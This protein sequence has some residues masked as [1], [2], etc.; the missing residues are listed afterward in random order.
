[1]MVLILNVYISRHRSKKNAKADVKCEHALVKP[2]KMIIFAYWATYLN[3][4]LS[5]SNG[6]SIIPVVGTRTRRISC[7]EGKYPGTAIRSILSR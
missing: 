5:K 3:I 4:I 6:Y 7:N 2:Q 1:M